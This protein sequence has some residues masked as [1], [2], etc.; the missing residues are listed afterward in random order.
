MATKDTVVQELVVNTLTQAQFDAAKEAGT[1]SPYELYGTPDTSVRLPILTPM[2]FDH[3]ANDV[4]WLRADTF[5][6]QSGDV[7][8]AAYEHLL[9]DYENREE[10]DTAYRLSVDSN[11]TGE[12]LYNY[13][14]RNIAVGEKIYSES[15]GPILGVLE[16]VSSGE[17][18]IYTIVV[19][20]T[21]GTSTEYSGDIYKD[22]YRDRF[23]EYDDF[24][25]AY[26]LAKDGH[27]I[28][29]GSSSVNTIQENA[30]ITAYEQTGVAWYYLLD[31]VNK[32][33]KLPRSKH[34]KYADTLGVVGTG[35]SLGLTDGSNNFGLVRSEYSAG[36]R[37]SAYGAAFGQTGNQDYDN[38]HNNLG[39]TEDPTKSGVIAQQAQ[40]TDQY[41]YLY[42]YVGNFEQDA[43]EQTAGLNAELFNGKADVDLSN[44]SASQSA[45]ETIV[46]WVIPDY[47]AGISLSGW[48][49]TNTDFTVPCAGYIQVFMATV[50]SALDTFYID[51]I[52]CCAIV[53]SFT[54]YVGDA[55]G[56][57]FIE[58]GV[59]TFRCFAPSR[60][61]SVIFYPCKGVN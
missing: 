22:S 26:Y 18:D 34:N 28:C 16:S 41:K 49:A 35:I 54:N 39:V 57:R 10:G 29:L 24:S 58:G 46:G 14:V 43:I 61:Q 45:K 40:D 27:K 19:K 9:D 25:V 37:G 42:F 7:Y 21:D 23:D 47:S 53:N 51:D 59:H 33:F 44:M 8:I 3:I 20:K 60:T 13:Y 38:Y 31:T 5:S 4:S 15:G 55:V 52:P 17:Y 30:V 32:Q 6:W 12:S 50:G 36:V 11:E 48:Q 2:W 1:L 56:G